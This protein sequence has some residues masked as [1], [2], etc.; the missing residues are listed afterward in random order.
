[1]L[2][3]RLS[4]K[5]AAV[6]G[7]MRQADVPRERALFQAYRFGATHLPW[8]GLKLYK[9]STGRWEMHENPLKD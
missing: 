8:H 1:M 5:A 7:R 6:A 2:M 4:L 3:I 9:K